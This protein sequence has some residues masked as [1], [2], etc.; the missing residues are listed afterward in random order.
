MTA[1]AF[2][3]KAGED[4][5]HALY[6][7]VLDGWFTPRTELRIPTCEGE[8]FVVAYGGDELPPLVLLHG[9]QSNA[10]VWM[11]DA[12]AWS[13]AFRCY[14][15]DMIG[16]A[17]FSA[18]SRPPLDRDAHARWLDDVMQGLG[19]QTASFVGVSLGG[20]LALDYARRRPGKVE[21]MAL[22]VPAGIG[23]QKNFLLKVAPL[24]LL[25]PWGARK[26]REMVFGP[27]QGEPPPFVR[28]FA[29]LMELVGRHIR[30]R[31]VKIPRLSDEEL[32]RLDMPML[33]IVA[34]KDVLIDSEDTRRRLA[35]CTPNGEVVYLPEA[36]HAIFG[37]SGRVLQ[38][39]LSPSGGEVGR[40]GP[41]TLSTAKV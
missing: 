40:G 15:I 18:P 1:S 19:L 41:K 6:R 11:F 13:K 28:P 37:Q 2:K 23:R 22:L 10:A 39:L 25:G 30:Q 31:I 20:W 14:A 21:R 9:A 17:G 24:F 3:T 36:R 8:T 34:G 29:E 38:F 12:P 26:I 27:S 32:S 35:K 4:A 7:Q 5:V 33:V 16:E